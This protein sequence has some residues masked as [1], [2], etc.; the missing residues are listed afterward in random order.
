MPTSCVRRGSRGR[1]TAVRFVKPLAAPPD[2]R[3][4]I[5]GVFLR[6]RERVACSSTLDE[7]DFDQRRES[8]RSERDGD[9]DVHRVSLGSQKCLVLEAYLTYRKKLYG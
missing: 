8:R 2:F 3:S 5:E 7:V 4:Y 1:S 9:L 6:Q